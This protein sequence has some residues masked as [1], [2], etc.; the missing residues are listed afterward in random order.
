MCHFREFLHASIMCLEKPINSSNFGTKR[1]FYTSNQQIFYGESAELFRSWIHVLYSQIYCKIWGWVNGG[2]LANHDFTLKN[3]FKN[4]HCWPFIFSIT[5][6]LYILN[7][8]FFP[9]ESVEPFRFRLWPIATALGALI[10][11]SRIFFCIPP[12]L[13]LEGRFWSGGGLLP[14]LST[15][16]F[17]A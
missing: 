4:K 11:T 9:E 16:I 15:C 13:F 7:Q 8:C 6:T 3:N 17:I 2:K 14:F 5:M 1:T 10:L 12:Y